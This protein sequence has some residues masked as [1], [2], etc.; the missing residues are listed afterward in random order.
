M[1]TQSLEAMAAAGRRE[2]DGQGIMRAE[3]H[4]EPTSFTGRPPFPKKGK[5]GHF[6]QFRKKEGNFRSGG[7][8]S[9]PMHSSHG[10]W[11]RPQ[12]SLPG[13][14]TEG[15]R[16]TTYPLCVRCERRHPGDCS[17]TSGRCYICRQEHRWRDCPYLNVACYHCGELGHRKWMCP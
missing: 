15:F 6:G 16:M 2:G 4:K 17:A 13:G 12:T 11:S 7:T 5:E 1:A 14:V 8:S 10:G 9:T 3:K